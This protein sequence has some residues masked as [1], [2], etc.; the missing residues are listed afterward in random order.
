M[1]KPC[2]SRINFAAFLYSFRW[3]L[4]YLYFASSFVFKRATTPEKY[5]SL[6]QSEKAKGTG[7]REWCGANR[8]APVVAVD[9][10]CR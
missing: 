4:L 6:L 10:L 7:M 2:G 1:G 3:L 5:M 8:K 9:A